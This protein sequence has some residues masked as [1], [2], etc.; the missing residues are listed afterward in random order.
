MPQVPGY[1]EMLGFWHKNRYNNP[2]IKIM[3]YESIE[4][5]KQT[6]KALIHNNIEAF[7]FVTTETILKHLHDL[8]YLVY[9]SHV[10]G[11]T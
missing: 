6:N 8:S 11:V 3:K 1:I 7:L 9:M 4:Q 5:R 2:K 10:P